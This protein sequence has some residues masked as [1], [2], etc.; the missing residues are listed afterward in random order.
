MGRSESAE[1]ACSVTRALD[2][3]RYMYD[4]RWQYGISGPWTHREVAPKT[5]DTD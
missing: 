3:I 5:G 4:K 2:T 1:R